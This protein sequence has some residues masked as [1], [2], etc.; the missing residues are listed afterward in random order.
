[1]NKV[2]DVPLAIDSFS[3]PYRFLS[4]F[5]PSTLNYE[6]VSYPTV[7]HAFQAA[8]TLDLSKRIEVSLLET[9]GQAKRA[10]RALELR[11][12]WDGIRNG[13]MRDLLLLK[14]AP[15]TMRAAMLVSTDDRELIEGNTW[16]DTYWG[17]CGGRG[18]NMLG[19]L[20]MEVRT[21]L[22]GIDV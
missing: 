5:S 15:G 12:D 19:K 6:G 1:M 17:V 18:K 2:Q 7:E 21:L 4:N 3:G 20:L 11:G 16:G 13:V 9:P 8:K 10:G 14:F 22:C